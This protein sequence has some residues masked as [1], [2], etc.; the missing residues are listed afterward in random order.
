MV[1]ELYKKAKSLT[2]ELVER[3][4]GKKKKKIGSLKKENLVRQ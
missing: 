3:S 1:V 2:Y 4:L